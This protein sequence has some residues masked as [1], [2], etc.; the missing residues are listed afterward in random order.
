LATDLRLSVQLAASVS[1][2]E[3]PERV[4][5]AMRNVLGGCEYR[6]ERS[7]DSI[8]LS[9]DSIR[10]LQKVQ[11][12][13]RDR[14]V[15]DAAR[16]LLLRGQDG[17]TLRLLLNRQAAAAGVIVVC[18]SELESPLGPLFLEVQ[19]HDPQGVIDWLTAH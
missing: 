16:R 11:D 14:R 15:R 3:D 2:S 18:S 8:V 13:L 1:P 4:L 5:A 9:S 6:V 7:P 19:T 10:C 12:Q 17:E